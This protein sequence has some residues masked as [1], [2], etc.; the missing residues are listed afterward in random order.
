MKKILVLL[1]SVMILT[2]CGNGT[3]GLTSSEV[4]TA[5]KDAGLKAEES[6]EMTKDDYG[7]APM[8]AEEGTIVKIGDD[9]NARIMSFENESDLNET[10]E[11]YD[12]LGEESAML[13]SWTLAKDNILIQMN[14][15]LPE[16]KYN[17][18]KE[19][20]EGL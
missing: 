1:F 18:Y 19:V 20:L 14:G 9:M 2:A 8:K 15:D 5:F 16:D 11:F 17:E 13:F 12:K 3:K 4:V 6:R 7:M 10:K